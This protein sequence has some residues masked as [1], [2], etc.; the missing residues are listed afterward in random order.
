M[1]QGK[2]VLGRTHHF[3]TNLRLDTQYTK[4][5]ALFGFHDQETDSVENQLVMVAKR[6]IWQQ[7]FKNLNP[8]FNA[9]A[10]YLLN[11]LETAK[12]VSVIKNRE[13]EFLGQWGAIID[14]LSDR[15]RDDPV[16]AAV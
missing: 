8:K 2:A 10:K 12:I 11:H 3:L 5:T 14:N 6:F 13:G 7:K 9:F 16:D 15:P 1:P 4:L